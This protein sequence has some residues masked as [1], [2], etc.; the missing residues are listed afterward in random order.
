MTAANDLVV[1]DDT[2]EHEN[3]RTIVAHAYSAREG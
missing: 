1:R 3:Q 2:A